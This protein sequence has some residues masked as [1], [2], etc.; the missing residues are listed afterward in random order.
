MNNEWWIKQACCEIQPFEFARKNVS[1][2]SGY[3][4]IHGSSFVGI[5]FILPYM[6]WVC[7]FHLEFVSV[8][9]SSLCDTLWVDVLSDAYAILYF[10]SNLLI[11][12]G[13]IPGWSE[14]H[15]TD[16]HIQPGWSTWAMCRIY[17]SDICGFRWFQGAL[18]MRAP[19]LPS[20]AV[21][22]IGI[23]VRRWSIRSGGPWKRRQQCW[24][25]VVLW[26]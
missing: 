24:W 11:G 14:L 15:W 7:L 26:K 9:M 2:L 22:L 19:K 13:I 20:S 17:S 5:I 3:F 23:S 25:N 12:I 1:N 6:Y 10:S 16:Y 21:S 4:H 8:I 18:I